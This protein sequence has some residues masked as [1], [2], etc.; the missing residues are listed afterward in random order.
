MAREHLGAILRV[1]DLIATVSFNSICYMFQKAYMHLLLGS[2]QM[3]RS[4]HE[5][6][7]QS[8]DGCVRMENCSLFLTDIWM[9]I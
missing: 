3:E 2:S 4:D 6:A 1:D 5:G 7:V 9:E 8:F